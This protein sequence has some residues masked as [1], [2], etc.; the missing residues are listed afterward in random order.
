MAFITFETG[1]GSVTGANLLLE[2]GS[3][4]V[5]VD[6]GMI[7]GDHETEKANRLPFAYDPKSINKLF[8]THAH[9]DHVGRI[10]KLVKDGFA[11]TIYSTPETFALAQLVM[12]DAVKILNLEAKKEGILPIYEHID[13]EKAWTLWKEIPYHTQTDFSGYSVYFKDAGHILGSSIIEFIE[14]EKKIVFTGDLG[15]T[16]TP[17]LR[18]TESIAGAH[19]LI[20]ESVYGDRNH[21]PKDERDAKFEK[22]VTDTI[23]RGGTLVIPSFSL[24]RTQV[25]LYELNN[26]AEKG[27]LGVPVYVDSPLATKVTDIYRESTELFN[28]RIKAQIKGG[29][30]VFDFKRLKFTIDHQESSALDRIPGP[31]VILAGSGMSMGGRVRHH[32][33]TYLPDPQNTILL[34]GYQPLG[35]LGRTLQNREGTVTIDKQKIKIRA[36][37]ESIFGYSS[38]KD[39]NHL[40]EF[41]ATGKD[42]LKKVFPIM[43]EPKASIFLAQRINDELDV[44][45]EYPE[46]GKRYEL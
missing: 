5:L 21:E 27:K 7:Q 35:T 41:V 22:I 23:A 2:I 20:M 30:D 13:V 4:R 37:I 14:G 1:I 40:V 18:D 17:L 34:V 10:G 19:Y 11:G 6:C 26:L 32:E 44:R 8:V 15:N 9:L 12:S 42:T 31:K 45:A 43:G 24:E 29:D 33:A 38:H 46:K 25:I 36:R 39:S 3:E 16:P 28:D